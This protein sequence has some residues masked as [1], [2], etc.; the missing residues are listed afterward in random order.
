MPET[1]GQRSQATG[2]INENAAARNRRDRQRELGDETGGPTRSTARRTH[3]WTR[4]TG[5]SQSSGNAWR[6]LVAGWTLSV[7]FGLPLI[8]KGGYPDASRLV[9]TMEEDS[10]LSGPSTIRGK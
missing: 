1:C 3:G 8:L 6:L 5:I 10:M 2:R 9:Q 4:W 7:R